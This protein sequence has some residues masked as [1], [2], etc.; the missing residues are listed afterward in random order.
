MEDIHYLLYAT[1]RSSA[2]QKVGCRRHRE[3][4]RWLAIGA[5]CPRRETHC[6]AAQ[7]GRIAARP[8]RRTSATSYKALGVCPTYYGS[9]SDGRTRKDPSKVV[10]REGSDG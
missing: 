4:L 2:F 6:F 7:R 5:G 1:D 9:C 10:V 3:R 8:C